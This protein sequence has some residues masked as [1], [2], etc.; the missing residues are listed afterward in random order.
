MLFAFE[1]GPAGKAALG[2]LNKAAFQDLNVDKVNLIKYGE[3]SYK[4]VSYE[5]LD[6]IPFKFVDARNNKPIVFRAILSGIS[7]TFTPDYASERY[8]GR[9]DNV[10]VLLLEDDYHLQN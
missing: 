3:D 10:F 7:D 2:G 4:D 5:N 9:P 1:R 6:W 8:V